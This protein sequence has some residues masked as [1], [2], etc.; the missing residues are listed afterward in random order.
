MAEPLPPRSLVA[1]TAL[2]VVVGAAV[3]GL[4]LTVWGADF[5]ILDD[6]RVIDVAELKS[7]AKTW[8]EP[9]A[10]DFLTFR[11]ELFGSESVTVVDA[12]DEPTYEQG[13]IPGAVPFDAEVAASDEN[14]AASR[15]SLVPPKHTVVVYCSGG[16]CDLSMQLARELI[17][18][19]YGR[20][21]VYEGGWTEWVEE[22]G[23][24]ET[25]PY[26]VQEG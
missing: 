24:E 10:V 21:M 25:G 26:P 14:Y 5:S 22:G 19:G 18:A 7:E 13:H 20:V 1:Q 6:A 16:S 9:K 4:G 12:R 11:T 3:G 15:R 23:E 17:E 8:T 2:L